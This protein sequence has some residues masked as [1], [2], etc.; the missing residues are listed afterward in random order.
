MGEGWG[1]TRG[2]GDNRCLKWGRRHCS[3]NNCRWV[4]AMGK[5]VTASDGEGVCASPA[6]HRRRGCLAGLDTHTHLLQVM[7]GRGR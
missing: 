7:G 1:G 6:E 4:S 5:A 3:C 2:A